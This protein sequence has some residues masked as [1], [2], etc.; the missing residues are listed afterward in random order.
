MKIGIIGVGVV[1]KAMKNGFENSHEIFLHDPKLGTELRDVTDNTDFSYIAVPTPSNPETGECDISIIESI[2]DKIPDG[3]RI[4]IKSTV[5]P[6]STK[7]LQEKYPRLIIGCS[8]EFLRSAT[9]ED[10]FKN[11]DLLV[12]GA[13]DKELAEE[14]F[15][16]HLEA[17]VMRKKQF[18]HVTPTQAEL[19]KYAKNSFYAMKVIFANQF[20]DLAKTLGEEWRDVKEIITTDQEQMI[21]PSHLNSPEGGNRGFGG[22]CLPK[23]ALALKF[24]LEK[25]KIKYNLI[26]AIID[27][28]NILKDENN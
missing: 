13:N 19:V 17:G 18:F 3:Q 5:I 11:Q 4:M 1:G 14:V 8:P 23:D 9:S 20:H 2:L 12:V 10:D 21:G 16:H 28:N 7:Y 26:Q 15:R 22:E 27:D 24:Q 25:M 6:G